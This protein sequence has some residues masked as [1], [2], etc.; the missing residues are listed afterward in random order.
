VTSYRRCCLH[1]DV[2]VRRYDP[3][4]VPTADVPSLAAVHNQGDVVPRV[5]G[6]FAGLAA[7]AVMCNAA[8]ALSAVRLPPLDDCEHTCYAS[9]HAACQWDRVACHVYGTEE[10]LSLLVTAVCVVQT[11]IGVSVPSLATPLARWELGAAVTCVAMLPVKLH[12]GAAPCTC[13]NRNN[14]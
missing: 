13:T 1:I 3:F 10:L 14:R 11:P 8:P 2:L 12:R 4:L 7:A 9:M 6:F 5:G